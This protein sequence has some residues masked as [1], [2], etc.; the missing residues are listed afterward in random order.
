[1]TE[2][3]PTKVQ[4]LILPDCKNCGTVNR[5]LIEQFKPANLPRLK[6][7]GIDYRDYDQTAALDPV[8]DRP[9][10]IAK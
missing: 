6:P 2:I 10:P 9:Q 4:A 7:Y 8:L 5:D 1:M 3:G